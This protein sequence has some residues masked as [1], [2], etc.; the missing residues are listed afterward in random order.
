MET[1]LNNHDERKMNGAKRRSLERLVGRFWPRRYK[2]ERDL[3]NACQRFRYAH[4]D[5]LD[6]PLKHQKE[7][8]EADNALHFAARSLGEYLS[9]K[10]RHRSAPNAE[11][12]DRPAPDA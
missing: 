1:T 8:N 3:V 7:Y 5:Y 6:N 11:M 10:R 12:R 4:E 2:L 9:Q